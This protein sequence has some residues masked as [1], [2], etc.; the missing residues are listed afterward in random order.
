MLPE[1][2]KGA[3]PGCNGTVSDTGYS[4]TD[5]FSSYVQN[6]FVNFVQCRDPSQPILLL[7]DGHRSHISLTLIQWA[8]RNN[9]I[10]FVLPPHTSHLLQPMDV[11]CFG[12]FEKLYQQE[13][14][15]FMRQSVGT[16]W[17]C[18]DGFVLVSSHFF[19]I[20]EKAI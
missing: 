5:V 16:F 4:N 19:T 14:H 1:L 6:H 3:S 20:R 15:K 7:Y 17:N 2:L 9:I 13:V 12:P 10:L 11:G 18:F 8:Q